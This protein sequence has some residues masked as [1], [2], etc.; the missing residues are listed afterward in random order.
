[1]KRIIYCDSDL[2]FFSDPKPIYKAWTGHLTFI[3]HQFGTPELMAKHGVYQAGM[4]GFTNDPLSLKALNWW[5]KKCIEWCYDNH[6]D[7]QRWG[8]QKYLEKFPHLFSS[9]KVN[10]NYG[11]LAA[12]WNIALNNV[13]GLEVTKNQRMA[14]ISATNVSYATTSA[15]Y[16]YSMKMNSIYGSRSH[17]TLTRKY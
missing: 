8:D 10:D 15:A 7:P 14:C 6:D 3:N 13:R 11:I 1:M 9:L 17:S 5:R 12:P 16:E 4:V 2:Y